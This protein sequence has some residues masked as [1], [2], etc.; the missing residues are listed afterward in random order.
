[1]TVK[2]DVSDLKRIIKLSID[3]PV[4]AVNKH[5]R[6]AVDYLLYPVNTMC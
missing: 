1:M 5:W 3:L 6:H 4:I 2:H